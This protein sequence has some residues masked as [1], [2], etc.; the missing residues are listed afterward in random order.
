MQRTYKELVT[1]LKNSGGMNWKPGMP[2][3]NANGD[4]SEATLGY[5]YVQ[6]T[7]QLI[8]AKT[9]E[10]QYYTIPFAD[11]VP[12]VVGDGA[13]MEGFITNLVYDSGG[14]FESGII[15]VADPSNLA[16]VSIGLAPI[17][18]KIVT[19]AKGYQYSVP[20][21]EKAMATNNWDVIQSKQNALK[22]NWDLGLQELAFL[23]LKSDMTSVPGLL[24][25]PNVNVNTSIIAQNIS[26]YTPTQF[27]TFVATLLADYFSGTNNTV[28]PD[29]LVI[30]M[31]D[32]LGLG[33]PI[34]PTFPTGGSMLEYLQRTF[35]QFSGNSS[36]LIKGVAYANA[37]AN[38]G[39]WAQNGT[40]RYC[41]YRR[42]PDTIRMDVPVDFLLN[43]P[44]TGNNFNWEGV[45][46]GQFTGA[47]VYRPTEVRYYDH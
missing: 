35:A 12:V 43:A 2:L 24:S 9:I 7:T 46:C 14:P 3:R 44:N 8:R 10:Q 18:A 22:R 28:L 16:Q 21:I 5:Q 34:S 33:V 19:W 6:Q 39:Y 37:S 40:N 1:Q 13:W 47:I 27:S 29:T 36:F 45:G 26:T 11:Y 15:S 41:L 20:E 17:P 23:G 4:I 32:Y 31:A 25:N 42:N 30:P 38:A